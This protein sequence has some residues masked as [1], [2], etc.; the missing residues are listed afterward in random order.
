MKRRQQRQLLPYERNWLLGHGLDPEQVVRRSEWVTA[1]VEYIVGAA[2]FLGLELKVN[3]AVLI[4]RVETEEL[5]ER[6][7]ELIGELVTERREIKGERTGDEGGEKNEVE[8]AEGRART[9]AR[10]M[11]EEVKAGRRETVQATALMTEEGAGGR[12]RETEQENR[13]AVAEVG[14]G[15]GAI[16]VYLAKKFPQVN[17]FAG[18]ISAAALAVA[19]ENAERQ[20]T[21]NLRLLESDLLAGLPQ[22]KYQLLVANLPYIPS[23]RIEQ[24]DLGVREHEPRLALDGGSDGLR[25]IARLLEELQT[26]FIT[27]E[28]RQKREFLPDRVWLEIDATHTWADFAPYSVNYSWEIVPDYQGLNRFALG[29]LIRSP[30]AR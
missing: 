25:L 1:P 22:R 15:S 23:A 4:P 13:L 6:A 7:A 14:T 8:V 30:T 9:R 18:D 5:A 20:A 3:P 27:S 21:A 16:S 11:E 12:R 29:R 2:Q 10:E 26:T 19:R 24:L 28:G 17:F